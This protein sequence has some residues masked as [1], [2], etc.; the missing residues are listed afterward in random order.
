MQSCQ[1][2]YLIEGVNIH[3]L[4][5]VAVGITANEANALWHTIKAKNY[6]EERIGNCDGILTNVLHFLALEIHWAADD[7]NITIIICPTTA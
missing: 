4:L 1:S 2:F 3:I 6:L 7:I 5:L